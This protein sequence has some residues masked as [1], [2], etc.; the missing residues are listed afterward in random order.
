MKTATDWRAQRNK[1]LET[2][3]RIVIKVGS[4]V[5]ADA[6]NGV[7]AEIV[8]ALSAG[9][10]GLI[11]QG[12]RV[13]MV[14]SGAVAAGRDA[15]AGKYN[16][17]SVPLRQAASAI[18]QTRLVHA[19]DKELAKHGRV[20][21]QVLLTRDDLEN[22]RR[23]INLKNTLRT[24]FDLGAVPIVNEND[25]V[26]VQ[27]LVY[28]DNDCLSGLLV[29]VIGAD[30][31]INLTS[32]AGVFDENP[33]ENPH[34]ARIPCIHD[35]GALDLDAMCA[36]KT[37]L[38]TGGMYSKL[39]SAKRA[40]K[41]STPTLILCGSDPDAIP[42]AFAGHDVGTW[43]RP[44]HKSMSRRKYW[45]AYNLE[46]KGAVIIDKGAANALRNK[47]KSLLPAGI[48]RVEGEFKAGDPVNI[49]LEK[50]EHVGAGLSNYNSAELAKV[51]GRKS[52][53]IAEIL[54]RAAHLEAVHRDDMAL[55][56]APAAHASGGLRTS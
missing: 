38:G 21:A 52:G 54:G 45:L 36:G 24:L 48:V 41:L 17:A 33:S 44:E 32:A 31:L 7:K 9:V 53:D 56:E 46:P 2:A 8:A 28:G 20:A 50:G 11:S 35:I 14:S 5:L 29:G 34:A 23:Y 39:V 10:A 6:D 12:R 30:L 15:M 51:K 25:S 43:I 26:A 19:Y 4:A 37:T 55:A 47:G 42:N 18:G 16:P 3:R 27:E 40:A 13:V 1:T 49:T 22:R